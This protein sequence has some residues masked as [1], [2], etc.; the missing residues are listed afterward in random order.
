VAAYRPVVRSLLPPQTG[1][2][3][4]GAVY[5]VPDPGLGQCHVRANFVVSVDG[6][7]EL[8]GRSHGLGSPADKAVFRMLRWCCDV[9]LVG[10]GTARAEDYGPVRVPD[11][12]QQWR[13]ERGMRAVPRLAVVSRSAALD[14]AARLFAEAGGGELPLVLT[15]AHA[16]ATAVAALADVAEVVVC[17][18][19]TAEPRRVLA[20][21]AARGLRRVLCE[22]GPSLLGAMAA[23][24]HLD[25]LCVTVSPLLAG[26]GH[27]QLLAGT[28]WQHPADLELAGV[29]EQ[30]STLLLRYRRDKDAHDGQ[31]AAQPPADSSS[32]SPM[33][34]GA[35]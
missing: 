5:A 24:G 32:S 14:P 21:L 34:A 3:D 22:G 26:P 25:E 31:S 15:T 20:A 13:R 2:V 23:A 16:D 10:A 9:A 6:A 19:D 30:D 1:E 4:L 11:Q 33:A 18:Q 12:R 28:P 29:L 17:G 7:A 35:P 8:D 27:L